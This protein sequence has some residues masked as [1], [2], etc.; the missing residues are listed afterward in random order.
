MHPID[1]LQR[2]LQLHKLYLFPTEPDDILVIDHELAVELQERL[3]I[4]GD[5]QGN[6][7]GSYDESTRDAF[8]K[9]SG[10]E[11][12]EERWFEDAHIDRVV[13]EFMRQKLQK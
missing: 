9:F 6:I 1:E 12:M 8:R 10:R 3:T 7:T 13:L 2:I 5:Y 4:S 11:N